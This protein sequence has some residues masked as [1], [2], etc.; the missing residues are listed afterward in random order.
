MKILVT[1]A[2]SAR[3]RGD[4]AI[5]EAMVRE[6]RSRPA[7]ADA[8]VAISSAAGP[9]EPGYPEPVV[10][11]F[12]SLKRLL[13]GKPFLQGLGFLAVIYPQ[14]LLWIAGRRFLGID[15][16][17][18]STLRSLLRDYDAADLVVA[19]GGG[20]L[21][22]RSAR[23][24][25][26][27]L[28][29]VIYGYHGAALLGKPTCLFSQSVGPFAGRLQAWLV[30]RSLHGVRLVLAR[31]EGTR[32]LLDS[33]AGRGMPRV[34]AA[35]DAAFLFDEATAPAGLPPRAG[36]GIRVGLT[37]RRWFPDQGQ[38]AGYEER[39]G[40]FARR[41]AEEM[42]A[43]AWFLPQVTYGAG[44]DD[45]RETA[46]RVRAAAGDSPRLHLVEDELSPAEMRGFCGAMDVFVGT[47]MHSNIFALSMGVPTLA[48][49]YQPKTAGIMAQLG[50]ERFV[51]PIELLTAER[52]WERF[53]RMLDEREA[54]TGA[55]ET[56]IPR[57]REDARRAAR[58]IE[59]DWLR[60]DD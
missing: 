36:D 35:A 13:S 30:K 60:H 6:L 11:S 29:S 57:L 22:T 47:R 18:W 2:Y 59:E 32:R 14:T 10:H 3:N 52:L 28:L 20:Y 23:R 8:E 9:E 4:A 37:V 27:V 15:L 49:G 33:W 12:T 16:P 46:R 53:K 50:L 44:G 25:Y 39:M 43:D 21:Y 51:L 45:D 17:V 48:V 7:F 42:G 41:L 24:G 54:I 19:A 40:R 31:E 55:L 5:V 1:N 38:Q 58:L 26:A 34:E 56:G